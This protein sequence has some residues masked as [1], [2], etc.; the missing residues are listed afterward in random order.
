VYQRLALV[1][2]FFTVFGGLMFMVQ[3]A[4]AALNGTSDEGFG[5]VLVGFMIVCA[6]AAA[7]GLYPLYRVFGALAEGTVDMEAIKESMDTAAQNCL[8]AETV[9][10]LK[11]ICCCCASAPELAGAGTEADGGMLQGASRN[12]SQL[13]QQVSAMSMRAAMPITHTPL[14]PYGKRDL[15]YAQKRPTDIELPCQSHTHPS[16]HMAKETYYTHKRDLLI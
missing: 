11:K 6:N 5:K 16:Y 3:A 4:Y 8:G 14:L 2:Q 10:S 7:A 15:L 1:S 9:D 12:I 13:A